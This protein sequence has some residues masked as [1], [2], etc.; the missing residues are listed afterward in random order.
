MLDRVT[1]EMQSISPVSTLKWS[2]QVPSEIYSEKNTRELKIK[3]FTK[4]EV[5]FFFIEKKKKIK[6]FKKK[7]SITQF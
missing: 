6:F 3:H 4:L 7:F 1:K 2:Q 5:N